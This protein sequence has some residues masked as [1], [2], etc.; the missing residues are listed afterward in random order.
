MASLIE[1]LE[2]FG[3]GYTGK[4]S[5]RKQMAARN[6]EEIRQKQLI[7]ITG[8]QAEQAKK[9]A[10]LKR[11]QVDR[12]GGVQAWN[13][14]FGTQLQYD[15][16]DDSVVDA[17]SGSRFRVNEQG[18]I[19]PINPREA[20]AGNFL[21]QVR[22]SGGV[23][24]TRPDPRT[25][26]PVQF[27][28]DQALVNAFAETGGTPELRKEAQG[29]QKRMAEKK[30]IADEISPISPADWTPESVQRFK[31][32]GNYDDLVPKKTDPSSRQTFLTES[33][34]R[35]EFNALPEVKAYRDTSFKFKQMEAAMARADQN[36]ESLVAVDQALIT[37]FNKM[38]DPDSVVH[39][40]EWARTP[41]SM[42]LINRLQGKIEQIRSGGAGL[43]DVERRELVGMAH[44]FNQIL[45]TRYQ[46][47]AEFYAS[48][49]E[50]NG[51]DP[52]ILQAP[53]AQDDD[54]KAARR[55]R[56][57]LE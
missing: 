10:I 16:S 5:W 40:S 28:G 57:G 4:P 47:A 7:E 53:Y 52:S 14:A 6:L 12:T 3:E 2:A 17:Q 27:N 15:Q 9:D 45:T 8:Q 11:Y 25:G 20:Q 32:S 24:T 42:G 50:R 29:I 26:K 43:T 18:Q 34:I 49:A 30:P 54:P 46:E 44:A 33:S 13:Q 36:P 19:V 31:L 21:A 37:L 35:K 1:V 41:E 48:A 39:V 51:L 55:K 56:W 22:G 23:A 38:T